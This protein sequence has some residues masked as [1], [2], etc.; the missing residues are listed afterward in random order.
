M[1]YIQDFAETVTERSERSVKSTVYA[2]KPLKRSLVTYEMS[3]F[4]TLTQRKNDYTMK[5]LPFISFFTEF[6]P[7]LKER[8]YTDIYSDFTNFYR[9]EGDTSSRLSIE[10]RFRFPYAWNGINTLVSGTLYETAYLTKYE[11]NRDNETEHRQLAKIEADANVQFLKNYQIDHFNIGEVQS[12]IKPRVRYTFISNSSYKDIP[13]IDP[14]DRIYK[15]N[16]I[17]YG[18]THYLNTFSSDNIRELSLF[19][20]EQTYSLSGDLKEST[21]YKGYGERLSDVTARLTIWPIDNFS[22]SHESTF[23]TTGDGIRIMRNSVEHSLQ[24]LYKVSL[25]HSYTKDLTNELYLDLIGYYRRLEGRYVMRYSF[26][27]GELLDATYRLT[28]RPTSCWAVTLS[29]VQSTRP[30]DTSIRISFDLAGITPG[31]E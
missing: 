23:S 24:K 28:Y 16:A 18:L 25:Y 31:K 20:I 21:F 9:E 11:D 1:D 30:N 19:E 12:L 15:T 5:Y 10:P 7:L 13:D 14:Y 2:E 22:F 4:R 6:I 8:F 27:D 3:Y 29:L 17:T 26:L